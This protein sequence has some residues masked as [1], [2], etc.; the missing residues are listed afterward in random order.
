M[1]KVV[2]NEAYGSVHL[3]ADAI[4][5]LIQ[6]GF[7]VPTEPL[8]D[9]QYADGDFNCAGPDGFRSLP[10]DYTALLK[11]GQVYWPWWSRG[12]AET[13]ALRSHSALVR[14]AEL[15]GRRATLSYHGRLRVEEV[16]DEARYRITDYDGAEGVKLFDPAEYTLG[17][18]YDAP[19]APAIPATS[20]FAAPPD[21]DDDN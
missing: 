7:P 9:T 5:L 19:A 2:V 12:T 3:S 16:P 17:Q 18:P 6:L 11:D 4:Y 14:M 15:L 20:W 13:D 1:K 8:E 10:G 21:S